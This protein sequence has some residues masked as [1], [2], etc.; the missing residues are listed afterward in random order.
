MIST[1]RCH[2]VRIDAI[3]SL[4]ILAARKSP[5]VA[6]CE[7]KIRFTLSSRMFT[8]GKKATEK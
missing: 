1:S 6:S 4:V 8:S 2:N 3:Y 5:V 7:G